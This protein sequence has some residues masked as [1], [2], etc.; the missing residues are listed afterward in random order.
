MNA[1]KYILYLIMCLFL[2]GVSI[3]QQNFTISGYIT[4]K[5][6]GE[7]LIGATIHETVGFN[8]TS[9][10]GYGYYSIALAEDH[11]FDGNLSSATIDV[12]QENLLG[13]IPN[14]SV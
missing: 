4:D 14:F 6:T 11:R 7:A 9:T 5:H 13:G 8:G 1:S 2:S 3:A 10:N 12:W